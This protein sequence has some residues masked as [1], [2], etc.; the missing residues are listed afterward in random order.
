MTYSYTVDFSFLTEEDGFIR[1]RRMSKA[2][3]IVGD[4]RDAY[5]MNE[6]TKCTSRPAAKKAELMLRFGRYTIWPWKN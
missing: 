2:I 5:I 3:Y 1:L 6:L 4:S